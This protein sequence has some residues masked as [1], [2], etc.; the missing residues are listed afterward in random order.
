MQH[1]VL[2]RS[3]VLVCLALTTV[4]PTQAQSALDSKVAHA[5][6]SSCAAGFAPALGPRPGTSS[7][8]LALASFDDGS[9]GGVELF[10]GGDFKR[11]GGESAQRVAKW[12][13]EYWA[14]VGAGM[15]RSVFAF[16][17]HD[18]G[19]GTA[20]F[21]AGDFD[22]AGGAPAKRVARWNG[23]SWSAVGGGMN[24]VVRDLLV[25]DDGGGSALYA[26][27][28]FTTADGAPANGVAV[29]DGTSWSPLGAGLTGLT[30]EVFALAEFDDGTGPA[31]FAGGAFDTAGGQ[32]AS[33][34]AK[35][36]GTSWSALGAGT[37]ARVGELMTH[38]DGSGP[39]LYVGGTFA[40]AGGVSAPGIARWDGA[41]WSAVGGGTTGQVRGMTTFDDGGGSRLYVTGDFGV[42]GGVPARSI[43]AWDGSAWTSVGG[44]LDLYGQ[45]LH[46]HDDGSGAGERLY[47][48]GRF[49]T[50]G[51][52]D[53][54]VRYVAT[55][56]G[57][58]WSG[59]GAG[60]NSDVRELAV[61]DAGAGPE[62][63]LAGHFSTVGGVSSQRF[64]KWD[65][66]A[67]TPLVDVGPIL[68]GSNGIKAFDVHDD[69]TGAG[70]RLFVGGDLSLNG[71]A[72][73]I[74]GVAAWNGTAFQ[75]V[76]A[77][78]N[79]AA[80][81]F[82]V[83]DEG[84]GTGPQLFAG[85]AFT[86]IGGAPATHIARWDGT[87]W[88]PLEAPS[89]GTVSGPDGFVHALVSHDDGTGAGAELFV[90]GAFTQVTYS[91]P[92]NNLPAEGIARWDGT[93]WSAV[94]GGLAGGKALSL[95]IF[96]DGSG[97]AL[98]AGGEF[99]T[100]G[101]QPAIGIA[102]WDGASWSA[103][104]TG[105]GDTSGA[106]VRVSALRVYDDG[107][108]AALYVGGEFDL[109][110]GAPALGLARWNGTSWS[111]LA[112]DDF[113][114]VHAF[115]TFDDGSGP[116]LFVAGAFEGSAVGDSFIAKWAGCASAVSYCTAGTSANGCQALLSAS[117]VP[118]ASAPSG[119]VVTAA[120]V[121]GN[122][123]GILIYGTSG[124]QANAWG[125]GSSFVCVAGPRRRGGLLNGAGTQGACDGS[126]AQDLNARWCSTCPKPG[127]NPGAGAIVQA[128]L[129]Y[130]DGLNTSNQTSSLSDAIEFVVSP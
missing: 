116:S 75:Q 42:A 105:L 51:T 28:L 12:D 95:A 97:P 5:A 78:M 109:A 67:W 11:A 58:A 60:P 22:L 54:H 83:H 114:T 33:R 73:W 104:G 126:F 44:G 25:H 53:L 99:T 18:D 119:F 62:L 72:Q 92:P 9:G 39:A 2:A 49:L 123:D 21:A 94:G 1:A 84:R 91:A 79:D 46:A 68:P 122:K 74:M 36:D 10:V 90:S 41:T 107:G 80:L 17:V 29:W 89:P 130:R 120:T 82:G 87:S 47:A 76:G 85:G 30:G 40:T 59:L 19:S 102:A 129:W 3:C 70:P 106:G 6:S 108:G 13:G 113:K 98:I 50:A 112:T 16:A 7:D 88:S 124:R 115:E 14:P 93:D 86:L 71:G 34:I 20:L 43:A 65:G 4:P 55:W 121:E 77:G 8:V 23:T 31:L 81:A 64:G 127:H 27:G 57:T 66:A 111:S 110:G 117:G 45:A 52:D 128:Q 63:Y 118:S 69:G 38:D 56:D 61:W 100:A 35:W 103:L 37:D 101:G 32:P 96:D 125:N 24:A 15:D 26:C 48:G